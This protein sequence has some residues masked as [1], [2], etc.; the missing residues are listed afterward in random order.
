MNFI[1]KSEKNVKRHIYS[2]GDKKKSVPSLKEVTA[3]AGVGGFVG[4]GGHEIDQLFAGGFHPDSGHG[5]QNKQLLAKQIKDR[6]KQRADMEKQAYLDGA[7]LIGNPDPIGGYFDVE[8][9]IALAAYEELGIVNQQVKQY[10]DENT[11]PQDVEWKS[12]GWDYDY[13][14][15][16]EG[17]KVREIEYDDNTGLYS[18][19]VREIEYDDE[20]DYYAGEDFINTSETNWKFINTG[21]K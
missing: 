19:M 4:R 14:E 13:D 6:K 7:E 11:P 16:G 5:S 1:E 17:Y 20:P 21:D 12:V 9:E 8:T 15:P 2:Y 18:S 10:N 3:G